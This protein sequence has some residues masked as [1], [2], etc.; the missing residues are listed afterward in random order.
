MRSLEPRPDATPMS[1]VRYTDTFIDGIAS[2]HSEPLLEQLDR[3]L[4]A[5]E[6]FPGLGSSDVRQSLIERYGAGNRKFPV[7]PFAIIYRYD[8]QA[9]LIGFLALP[10]EK[11]VR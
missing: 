6:S 3:R 8:E 7:P 11:T 2:I 9:D 10:Y 1:S 5:I 4:V